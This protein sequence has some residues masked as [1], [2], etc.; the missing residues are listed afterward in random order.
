MNVFNSYCILNSHIIRYSE[1]LLE[2]ISLI[3]FIL[4]FNHAIKAIS[5]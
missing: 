5:I 3:F 4:V 1:L 2:N